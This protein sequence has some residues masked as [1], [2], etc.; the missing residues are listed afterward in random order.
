[1]LSRG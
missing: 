1:M